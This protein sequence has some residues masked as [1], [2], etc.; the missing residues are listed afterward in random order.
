MWRDWQLYKV[1][2][3]L[4]CRLASWKIIYLSKGGRVTLIKNTVSN[5]STYYMSLFPPTWGVANHIDKIQQYFLW[6]WLSEEFKFHPVSWS[7]VC[8]PIVEGG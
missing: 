6:G 4:L 3:F 5:L 2:G 1:E 8:S 7:K